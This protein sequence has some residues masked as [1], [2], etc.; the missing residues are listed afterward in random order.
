[1]S[2]PIILISLAYLQCLLDPLPCS[3]GLSAQ[4]TGPLNLPGWPVKTCT[5]RTLQNYRTRAVKN[6]RQH[7]QQHRG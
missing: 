2:W 3:S 6:E 4:Q 7:R 5:H 1:M